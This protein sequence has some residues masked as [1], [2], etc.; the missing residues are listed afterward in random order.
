[1]A[2]DSPV[3]AKLEYDVAWGGPT[4]INYIKKRKQSQRAGGAGTEK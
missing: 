3:D 4:L 1:M 2:T